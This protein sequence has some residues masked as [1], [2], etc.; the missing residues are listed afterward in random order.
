MKSYFCLFIS[1]ICI[2]S[3]LDTIC[4]NAEGHGQ[5]KLLHEEF[6]HDELLNQTVRNSNT[7]IGKVCG[8]RND[9]FLAESFKI[10]IFW[11]HIMKIS[12]SYLPSYIINKTIIYK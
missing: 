7:K 3:G 10:D 2:I 4:I 11:Q 12:S 8:T 1:C 6:E 9:V 5:G